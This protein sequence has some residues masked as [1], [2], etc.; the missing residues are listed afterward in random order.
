MTKE[1]YFAKV[2]EKKAI[3][4]RIDELNKKYDEVLFNGTQ[5]ELAAHEAEE[6]ELLHE[7]AAIAVE[8][9]EARRDI[10]RKTL[11]AWAD[12]YYGK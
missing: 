5:E 9:E 7:R 4:A 10:D 2:N 11:S 12:E 1:T 8:L 3:T 6:S